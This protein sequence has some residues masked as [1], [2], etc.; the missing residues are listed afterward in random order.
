MA[1]HPPWTPEQNLWA[2]VLLF[3]LKDLEEGDPHVDAWFLCTSEQAYLPGGFRWIM[4]RLNMEQLLSTV[5]GMVE[6]RAGTAPRPKNT[7]EEGDYF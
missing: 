7:K 1:D 4:Q 5:M 2:K 3:A 6:R